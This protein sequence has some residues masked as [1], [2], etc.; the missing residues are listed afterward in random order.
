MIK[1]VYGVIIYPFGW[2]FILKKS[3]EKLHPGYDFMTQK[4]I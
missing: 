3:S 4:V 1:A 2:E